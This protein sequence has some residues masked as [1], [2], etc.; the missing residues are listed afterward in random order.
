MFYSILLVAAIAGGLYVAKR[1]STVPIEKRKDFVM[2][3]ALWGSAAIVVLLVV[4]GRA[5]WLMGVLAALIAVAGRAMQLA[6]FVPIFKNLFGDG[7]VGGS[8]GQHA[9]SQNKVMTRK[10]AAQILGVDENASPEE[11]R[12]AHKKLMQKI[13]PDR[14]GTDALAAQI[15]NAKEILIG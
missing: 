3:V 7:Q 14:G 2:K 1:W 15:N 11:V 6:Q 9:A 8:K 10:D 13:H 12:L 5:H 4:G